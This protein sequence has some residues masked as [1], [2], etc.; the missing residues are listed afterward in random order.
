V[1]ITSTC[2]KTVLVNVVTFCYS[3]YITYD[4]KCKKNLKISVL[5]G[6]AIKSTETSSRDETRTE[7]MH[8][9]PFFSQ[10]YSTAKVVIKMHALSLCFI[11]AACFSAFIA[12]PTNTEIFKFFLPLFVYFF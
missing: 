9:N 8:F 11:S 4:N 5:V 10:L 2:S 7:Y 6:T 3:Y 12:V 1:T